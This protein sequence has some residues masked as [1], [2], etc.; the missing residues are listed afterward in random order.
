MEREILTRLRQAQRL[1]VPA[2]FILNGENLLI[3]IQ[4]EIAQQASL[5]D[6]SE[7][8]PTIYSEDLAM[9]YAISLGNKPDKEVFEEINVWLES[10]GRDKF[11]DIAEMKLLIKEFK[12][13]LQQELAS[14]IQKLQRIE[15][16]QEELDSQEAL[17]YTEFSPSSTL[18]LAGFEW[19]GKPPQPEDA[20][21]IF[22]GAQ[23]TADAPYLHWQTGL[24]QT[25]DIYK[26]YKSVQRS[27]QT[28]SEET[29]DLSAIQVSTDSKT[30]SETYLFSVQHQSSYLKSF[31]NIEQNLLQTRVPVTPDT[32]EILEKIE[33]LLDVKIVDSRETDMEG[34]AYIFGAD[35]DMLL[36]SHMILNYE[37][38]NTFFFTRDTISNLTEAKKSFKIYY[39]TGALDEKDTGTVVV[40]LTQMYSKGETSVVLSDGSSL[41]LSSDTPYLEIKIKGAESLEMT[42]EILDILSRLLSVYNAE[43]GGLET[44]YLEYIPEYQLVN[45]LEIE[46]KVSGERDTKIGRLTQ[47]APDIFIPGYARKCLRQYQPIVVPDEEVEEWEAKTF[48]HNG[49]KQKRQVMRFPPDGPQQYNFV[50][51]D[52][53]H[54]YPGVKKNNLANKD[55]YPGLPCCFANDQLDEEAK[56]KYNK[57]YRGQQKEIKEEV[58]HLVKSDKIVEPGRYGVLPKSITELFSRITSREIRRRGVPRSPNS[59]LHCLAIA[60]EDK[61][62]LKATPDQRETRI[63]RLRKTILDKTQ[64][65]LVRQQLYDYTDLEIL[66]KW[67]DGFFD[68]DLYFRVLEEAYKVNIF[69]FAPSDDETKRLSEKEDSV[70]VMHLPRFKSFYSRTPYPER[71]VVC[72]YRTMGS[73]RDA[74]EY[75]QCELIVFRKDEKD[76]GL[77][78]KNVYQ[79]L[80]QTFLQTY[81][82]V[83][84]EL[85]RDI[86][87]GNVDTLAR[88]NLY[89]QIDFLKI[90]PNATAQYIDN[91]GKMRGLYLPLSQDGTGRGTEMMISI[92]PS[93]PGNLPS[94][95]DI[96]RASPSQIKKVLTKPTAKALNVDQQLD[97]LW[98]SV[99]DLPYGL[100]VPTVSSNQYKHLIVG[101]PSPLGQIGVSEVPRIYKL[102]R[103]LN[104]LVQIFRWLYAV[105]KMS[106]D[107]FIQKYV[108]ID[109]DNIRA[110]SATIYDFTKVGRQFPK[111]TTVEEGIREMSKRVPTLFSENRLYMYSEKLFS[112]IYY[113]TKKFLQERVSGELS[114][115]VNIVTQ[116]LTVGD[117]QSDPDVAVF[118]S[119][120]DLNNW[121]KQ[122]G[123][124]NKIWTEIP[125]KLT[126]TSQPY[127]YKD[128]DGHI[129]LVQNVSGGSLGR[130]LNVAY[131]WQEYRINL[132]YKQEEELEL[133]SGYVVYGISSSRTLVPIEN[134]AGDSLDF[135]S[136]VQYNSKNYGAM[137]RL[138]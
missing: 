133:N 60:A 128:I 125:E 36:L 104:Y 129:Y 109:R 113:L 126:Y 53:Q 58:G 96:V 84:W 124:S 117:F 119:Q 71:P 46:K 15:K 120:H 94:R 3:S 45:A 83:T 37:L 101:P 64:P 102:Q 82:T 47:A 92:I 34:K 114:I 14:D 136:V 11:R 41:N 21:P 74:S 67:S 138:L 112:G 7:K 50:C 115:P 61:K 16:L 54:P 76:R 123:A 49:K 131:Y 5:K 6:L 95:A 25:P 108:G 121:V 2:K 91:W 13:K 19:K 105:S 98:F 135:Y 93:A 57:I 86:S 89:S 81:Q 65:G 80:Y 52:D 88:A 132:G 56:S 79:L 18:I 51:P 90:F 62:Y 75:A 24:H 100:F 118:L 97:G 122:E 72:I 110:D 8:F 1:N 28:T 68:P 137:L 20:Y 103:D 43:V 85:V 78:G 35:V 55:K 134:T 26:I 48:F 12:E 32:P 39:R 63:S 29:P 33:K 42:N 130:A 99:L 77:F 73:E 116:P 40:S 22:D 70:G 4:K 44:L 31:Y 17:P 106:L 9:I 59:F 66:D 10:I 38:F 27:E 69:V 30:E 87:S 23:V 111:V 107:D 127:L